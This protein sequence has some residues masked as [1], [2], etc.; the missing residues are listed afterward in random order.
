MALDIA[1][2]VERLAKPACPRITGLV[3]LGQVSLELIPM[4]CLELASVPSAP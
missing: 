3:A 2:L 1:E 4:V